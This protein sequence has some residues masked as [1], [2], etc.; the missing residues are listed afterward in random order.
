[1]RTSVVAGLLGVVALGS[2][3]GLVGC[4]DDLPA[5]NTDGGTGGRGGGS[6]GRDGA[7]GGSGPDGGTGGAAGR[8]GGTG[9]VDG[10]PTTCPAVSFVTPTDG[11]MLR[12]ADDKSGDA[13]ANGFQYDIVV[14]V[15]GADNTDVELHG[16]STPGTVTDPPLLMAGKIQGGVVRFQNVQLA[17]TGTTRLSLQIGGVTCSATISVT[18]DCNLPACTISK[19]NHSVL[20]GV[21]VAQGGDR[22]SSPGGLFQAAFEVTTDIEDGR[23]V[24]LSVSNVATPTA[25]TMVTVNAMSGKATFPGVT[26]QPDG[27]YKVEARCTNAANQAGRSQQL[28]SGH[29]DS[30]PK[31]W[32]SHRRGR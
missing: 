14:S 9:G 28:T 31:A 8:D 29:H 11:A 5:A 7:A 18:V 20:N 22:A 15:A 21:P 23:P 3:G 16:T 4:G 19:P 30:S 1:M 6:G 26:L 13:C 25:I 27:D 12:A 32:A 10:P 2:A 24:V 17:S